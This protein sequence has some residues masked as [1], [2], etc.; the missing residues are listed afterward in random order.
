MD[1]LF[2]QIGITCR[3]GRPRPAVANRRR[4]VAQRVSIF[5]LALWTTIGSQQAGIAANGIV[6]VS[7]DYLIRLVGT[8]YDPSKSSIYKPRNPR[9][10]FNDGFAW[11][12]LSP[13]DVGKFRNLMAAG[14]QQAATAMRGC[15]AIDQTI[16]VIETDSIGDRLI[17]VIYVTGGETIDFG[18]IWISS[19]LVETG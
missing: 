9:A 8:D 12:C 6:R 4:R 7:G 16:E 15:I 3:H 11:L 18:Q 14:E 17:Q 2:S 1:N 19:G 5:I 13:S 10:L